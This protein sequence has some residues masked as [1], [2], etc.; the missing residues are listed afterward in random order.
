MRAKTAGE[1]NSEIVESIFSSVGQVC[2]TENARICRI[3]AVSGKKSS[4]VFSKSPA[5]LGRKI[6]ASQC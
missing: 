5:H 6:E 3:L 2:G 1:T 4:A